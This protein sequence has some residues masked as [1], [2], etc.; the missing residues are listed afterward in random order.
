M[1]GISRELLR[2][3]GL[4]HGLRHEAQL[5]SAKVFCASLET[6]LATLAD[7]TVMVPSRNDRYATSALTKHT[8]RQKKKQPDARRAPHKKEDKGR[9][10]RG[11]TGGGGGGGDGGGGGG[12]TA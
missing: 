5:Q 3:L 7:E 4:D 9:A 8:K 6:L 1:R 12:G 2:V 11:D 10:K